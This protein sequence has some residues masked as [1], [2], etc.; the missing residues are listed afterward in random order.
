MVLFGF[1]DK[2]GYQSFMMFYDFGIKTFLWLMEIC[3]RTFVYS[4]L[5]NDVINPMYRHSTDVQL[6][7]IA[8]LV[9]A[10]HFFSIVNKCVLK[11]HYKRN[12]K[13]D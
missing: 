8:L 9:L 6:E 2:K 11:S 5:V 7:Y 4:C 1:G 13:G 12:F 3:L 10:L